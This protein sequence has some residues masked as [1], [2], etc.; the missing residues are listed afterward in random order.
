VGSPPLL[1][2]MPTPMIAVSAATHVVHDTW[3][4]VGCLLTNTEISCHSRHTSYADTKCAELLVGQP[5]TCTSSVPYRLHG[6]R[7]YSILG[8]IHTS[9]T[10]RPL[11]P[12]SSGTATTVKVPAQ[13]QDSAVST[14]T[15]ACA[16]TASRH[17]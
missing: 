5:C 17:P 8:Y 7:Q 13:V 6:E 4:H 16:H 9:P 11:R 12:T 10:L 15:M 14:M 3:Q 2:S 1:V